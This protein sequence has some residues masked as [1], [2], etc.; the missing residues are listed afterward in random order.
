MARVL[1]KETLLP[2]G[3]VVTLMGSAMSYGILISKVDSL[4]NRF[5]RL[6]GYILEGKVKV[7]MEDGIRSK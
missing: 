5:T 6:E 4:E 7:V 3:I 1:S 2:L